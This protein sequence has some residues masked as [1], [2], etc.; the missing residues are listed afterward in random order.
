M[1]RQ[2]TRR[3][4]SDRLHGLLHGTER[5]PRSSV[6]DGCPCS[7]SDGAAKLGTRSPMLPC[8][9][10]R[11]LSI[12]VDAPC[13]HHARKELRACERVR[14]TLSILRFIPCSGML[15][16]SHTSPNPNHH[17]HLPAFYLCPFR[18]PLLLAQ[19]AHSLLY[20][21]RFPVPLDH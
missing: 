16:T 14:D 1:R 8:T 21:L 19:L 11:L 20:S 7:G 17:P 15:Y 9:L 12:R 3:T 13:K 6:C 18:R 10:L 5:M 2:D 4:L